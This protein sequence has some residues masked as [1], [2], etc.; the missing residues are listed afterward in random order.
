MLSTRDIVVAARSPR[1]ISPHFVPRII[2]DL[3]SARI[4]IHNQ[5]RGPNLCHA[6]ACA[7][8]A[9]AVAQV[10][11]LIQLGKAT[12]MV[13]GEVREHHQGTGPGRV[14]K[15]AGTEHVPW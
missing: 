2:P 9:A 12:G 4:A 8:S 10:A 11:E 7:A 6:E 14:W 5:L 13:A 1:R 15:I 3:P